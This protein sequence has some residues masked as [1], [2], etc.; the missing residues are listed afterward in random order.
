MISINL[1]E[2]T[3]SQLIHQEF[4]D[5]IK[6]DPQRVDDHHELLRARW[7]L[8]TR[9][10]LSSL[11]ALRKYAVK[12]SIIDVLIEEPVDAPKPKER[13]NDKYKKVEQ[14]C[15]DNHLHQATAD[16]V[17]E[18]G[19]FT[20]QTA[21]RF[22]KDRPDLFYRLRRNLYELKNPE[23]VRQEEAALRAGL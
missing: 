16:D 3:Y 21:L 5:N 17:A 9:K 8:W 2:R 19:G 12:R 15:R 10:D 20:Y 13:R 1:D 23:I 18:I 14:W 11:D 22:I 7:I 4:C 6:N